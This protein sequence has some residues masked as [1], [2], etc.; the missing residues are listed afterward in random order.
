LYADEVTVA[1]RLSTRERINIAGAEDTTL[2][3]SFLDEWLAEVPSDTIVEL[4]VSAENI[5]YSRSVDFILQR[6]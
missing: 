6:L 4:D 1:G 3:N 5:T 2:F